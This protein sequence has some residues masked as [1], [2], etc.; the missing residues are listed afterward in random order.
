MTSVGRMLRSVSAGE[1]G[2]L[3]NGEAG[4]N[5]PASIEWVSDAFASGALIRSC[6]AHGT[7]GQ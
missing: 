7:Y 6:H 4:K 2:L 1:R 5:A 3:W